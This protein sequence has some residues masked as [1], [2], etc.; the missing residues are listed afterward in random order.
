MLIRSIHLS[1]HLLHGEELAG[2][3]IETYIQYTQ[4]STGVETRGLRDFDATSSGT[5]SC[6]HVTNRISIAAVFI[7][8]L[9]HTL[10]FLLILN[11]YCWF[12]SPIYLMVLNKVPCNIP[13]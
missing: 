13:V 8:M 11:M 4:T 2:F 3:K 7:S 5:V 6:L 12:I 9:A 1:I 10:F